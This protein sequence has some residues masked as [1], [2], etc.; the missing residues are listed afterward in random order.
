VSESDLFGT[1]HLQVNTAMSSMQAPA[2]HHTAPPTHVGPRNL[3][4]RVMTLILGAFFQGTCTQG[5]SVMAWSSQVTGSFLM[6]GGSVK[7]IGAFSGHL[8]TGLE[9]MHL[10][11][12]QGQL[13]G[14]VSEVIGATDTR[15]HVLWRPVEDRS[16][17]T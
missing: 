10:I 11:T 4:G 5:W 3:Y 17:V 8:H 16:Q 12:C 13:R 14:W 9:C 6:L 2:Q 7:S 1:P 15:S